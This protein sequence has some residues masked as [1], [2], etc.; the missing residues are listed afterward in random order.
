MIGK[1]FHHT[2]C[3]VCLNACYVH[4]ARIRWRFFVKQL[5]CITVTVNSP[6]I[7]ARDA[8]QLMVRKG[9]L[10][11]NEK[12]HCMWTAQQ[13]SA[14]LTVCFWIKVTHWLKLLMTNSCVS[15]LMWFYTESN[16][17][18]WEPS[19]HVWLMMQRALPWLIMRL[20]R[21]RQ[22]RWYAVRLQQTWWTPTQQN[23]AIQNSKQYQDFWW[24]PA[25][26][27]QTTLLIEK[28][29]QVLQLGVLS[30]IC[31]ACMQI[32]IIRIIVIRYSEEQSANHKERIFKHKLLLC[33][34]THELSSF[35]S[36]WT[37]H[38]DLGGRGKH[39]MTL[40]SHTVQSCFEC[41]GANHNIMQWSR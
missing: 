4:S 28:K 10:L 13:H 39:S 34:H 40:S 23:T 32:S 12:I 41:D 31:T 2:N 27:F 9:G 15:H 7:R 6:R 37:Q 21:N 16:H 14:S 18:M 3:I 36:C 8:T 26:D 30:T 1:N 25:C 38:D 24:V 22:N 20:N 17:G 5:N 33:Q 19:N 11:Q 29:P 35:Y